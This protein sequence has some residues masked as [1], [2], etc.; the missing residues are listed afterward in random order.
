MR[1]IDAKGVHFQTLNEQVRACTD[2]EITLLNVLG[3]RYIASGSGA[4]RIDI[5]GTPGNALAA[6]CDGAT[7]HVHGN[8]Q[9]ALGDTMNEGTVVV[10]GNA[11]DTMGYGMRGGKIFI[12][13]SVG[14]R[15]GIHMKA[16]KDKIPVVIVGKR[17]GCFL[18]EYQAGGTIVVLGLGQ[19]DIPV[20][21][22]CGTGMHG[23]R[24]FIRAD[25]LPKDLP[26]QIVSHVA[27]KEE[28]ESIRE[29]VRQFCEYFGE[30]LDRVMDHKFHLLTPNSA[31]P[32]KQMYTHI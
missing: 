22:F 27:T 13:D 26:K 16:Y 19:D 11:G 6:Y 18:G 20:G 10:Y 21:D 17:A 30:D 31:N 24:I 5:Y 12:R 29:D 1:E 28:L 32:Y 7:I 3:Q 8:A 25:E 14:Y 15:A 9:D 2:S 23:G 4:R